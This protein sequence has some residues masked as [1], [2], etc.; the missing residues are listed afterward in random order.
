MVLY[1]NF[2]VLLYHFWIERAL[3]SLVDFGKGESKY[4]AKRVSSYYIF[5]GPD[6]LR[7]LVFFQ[8]Q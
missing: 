7:T 5:D 2:M 8:Y 4:S 1:G 3:D 6:G